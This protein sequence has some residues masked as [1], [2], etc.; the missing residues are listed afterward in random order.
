MA[1]QDAKRRILKGGTPKE[2]AEITK[3]VLT[4]EDRRAK[5][6]V[7]CLNAGAVLYLEGLTKDMIQGVRL[8]ERLI[9]DGSA[10]V[11]LE[12]FVEETN[13]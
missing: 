2:N 11:K 10:K 12:E 4:G 8:S 13:K 5:R 6:E 1:I 7:V 3:K 9:D